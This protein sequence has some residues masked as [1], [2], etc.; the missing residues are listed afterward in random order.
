MR[1]YTTQIVTKKQHKL[2]FQL[3]YIVYKYSNSQE[4]LS[5]NWG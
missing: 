3:V 2:I 4:E 5:V 1:Q